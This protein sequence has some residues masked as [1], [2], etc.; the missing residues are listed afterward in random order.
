MFFTM[1]MQR[2]K[3]ECPLG[4]ALRG[5]SI[6]FDTHFYGDLTKS[7]KYIRWGINSENNFSIPSFEIDALPKPKTL[8]KMTWNISEMSVRECS[9]ALT[10]YPGA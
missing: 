8:M 7:G 2:R 6:L 3:M 1:N 9:K 4:P 5:S 10:R